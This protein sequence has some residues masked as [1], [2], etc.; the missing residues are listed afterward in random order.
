MEIRQIKLKE[1]I[2]QLELF[3]D[4]LNE[5]EPNEDFILQDGMKFDT[6]EALQRILKYIKEE[7]IPRAVVKEE[8]KKLDKT[9]KEMKETSDFIIADTIQPKIEILQKIL[10]KGE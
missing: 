5:L 7:N 3:K 9:Y 10:N 2:D 4:D 6:I 8:I 1:A